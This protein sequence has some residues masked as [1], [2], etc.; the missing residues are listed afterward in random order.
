MIVGHEAADEVVLVVPVILQPRLTLVL[1]VLQ[2]LLE[3][4]VA[5][6]QETTKFVTIEV[7]VQEDEDELL[8]LVEGLP[9]S[10]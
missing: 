10:P 9:S 5:E 3:P 1:T 2:L 4:E 8:L 7:A 6:A